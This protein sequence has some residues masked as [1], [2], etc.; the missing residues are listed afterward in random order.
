MTISDIKEAISDYE[1]RSS[2]D[3]EKREDEF[4]KELFSPNPEDFEIIK[5]EHKDKFYLMPATGRI[6]LLYR[7]QAYEITPCLP[8]LYRKEPTELQIFLERMRYIE[9]EYLLN[10]HLLVQFYKS[11]GFSPDYEGLAQHYGLKT[12]IMDFSSDI[13][14]AL[15]FAMCPYDSA[16][17]EY[18]LPDETKPL[19]GIIYVINPMIFDTRSMD[20]N[21]VD[22]FRSIVEPI[23]LQPFD[24]PAVQ[25]GYGIRLSN[26]RPLQRARVFD[27]EY[28]IEEA[29]E[30]FDKFTN[31]S[32]L[33]VKDELISPVKLL[34]SKTT[35]APRIFKEAWDRFPIADITKSQ[36]HKLLGRQL[37]VKIER[38]T[39]ILNFD[40]FPVDEKV[41]ETRWNSYTNRVKSRRVLTMRTDTNTFSERTPYRTTQDLAHTEMLRMAS[42]G[43]TYPKGTRA[44]Q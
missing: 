26:K 17:D 41:L 30:Y 5:S 3:Y 9:F 10:S 22:A 36:C 4:S 34:M 14:I 2:F 43:L 25:R 42:C 23:G 44:C 15:F 8:T 35:F 24:R 21:T 12:E 18:S 37:G 20:G 40:M 39:R 31:Q 32:K 11:K 38:N 29:K 1:H 19:K 33:W 7:G 28:S 16:T 13:D 6:P 27:F